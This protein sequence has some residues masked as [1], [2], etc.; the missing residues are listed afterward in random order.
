MTL[1]S[2]NIQSSAL[3]WVPPPTSTM[4]LLAPI[5]VNSVV[6]SRVPDASVTRSQ[7]LQN[8][9]AVL[10]V[11]VSFAFLI[12]SIVIIDLFCYCDSFVVFSGRDGPSAGISPS[13]N[14]DHSPVTGSE[15]YFF[16]FF[17]QFCLLIYFL[18]LI[19]VSFNRYRFDGSPSGEAHSEGCPR[20]PGDV[21]FC[22]FVFGI[23]V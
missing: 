23:I 1:P 4:S 5:Q 10:N 20:L 11:E 7:N 18:L 21:C 12:L 13:R 15:S 17:F 9:L 8:C 19:V 22:F 14:I 3:D 16:V 2:L 6:I